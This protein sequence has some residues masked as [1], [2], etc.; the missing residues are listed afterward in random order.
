MHILGAGR[1]KLAAISVAVVVGGA[2]LGGCGPAGIV[3]PGAGQAAGGSASAPAPGPDVLSFTY[4]PSFPQKETIDQQLEIKNSFRHSVVPTLSFTALDKRHQVL[5]QVKVS[6]VFGSDRGTL[7]VHYGG[8]N[9]IL[10]FSGPGD[11]QVADVRVTVKSVAL[12]RIPSGIHPVEAQALDSNGHAVSKFSRFS[13]VQLTNQDAFPVSVRVAYLVY[14][15][16][17]QGQTQ[18]AV[19]VTEIGG[20]INVPTKGTAVVN[21]TGDAASAVARYSN[22]P[23]V[24]IKPYFS[25]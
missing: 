20:L 3:R 25:Q 10:R 7:V 16:L 5:P 24:S 9:D 4:H 8:G 6:T 15:Q 19:T 2:L 23:A 13:A 1:Q 18:Q 17:P 11:H 22:G 14:D 12:A 21:V